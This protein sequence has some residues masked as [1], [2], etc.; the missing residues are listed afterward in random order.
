MKIKSNTLGKLQKI[1]NGNVFDSPYIFIR[2][3]LQNSQRSKASN[4]TF[5]LDNDAFVCKDDGCGCKNPENVFTLDL[6]EWESTTE[7][8]GIGFW[9]CLAIPDIKKIIV[10]SKDWKCTVDA[11]NLFETGDLTVKQEKAEMIKGFEVTIISPWFCNFGEYDNIENYL[12][13]VAKYLPMKVSINEFVVPQYDIFDNYKATNFCKVYD[14]RLFKAK[15]E[16]NSSYYSNITLYYEKRKV[17][18][19]CDCDYV[20]GIIEAKNGKITLKEPDRTSYTR[21]SKLQTFLDKL[22]DCIKDLYKSYVQEN[23]VENDDFVHGIETWLELKDYEK[24][25]D[26]DDEM[27]EE[28]QEII[29]IEPEVTVPITRLDEE[30]ASVETFHK[31]DQETKQTFRVAAKSNATYS[32][33]VVNKAENKKSSKLESFK[34][35]IKKMKKSVWVQKNEYSIYS[36]AIQEAKYKGLNVIVAKNNLYAQALRNYGIVHIDDLHNAFREVYMKKN[37]ELKNGKEEAFI[38]LLAPI[39]HKYNLPEDTFLIADLSIESQFVVDDKIVFKRN[40]KN[41]KNAIQ[42]YGV[43][44]RR[45]IYLDRNAIALQKFGLKQGNVHIGVSEI[46]ALLH[47]VNTIAHEL[48]HLIEGTT[49]NTPEHYQAEIRHQQE[50]ISLYV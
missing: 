20:C 6:S 11:V 18:D 21:D 49:D 50:I 9:S 1:K 34:D 2:E 31:Q 46:K 37:I 29:E 39:C 14:N 48:A 45:Y 12:F 25:L 3:L 17:R 35:K 13:D 44:D 30:Q 22:Q 19:F 32:E 42:I 23:G 36:D 24:M 38:A 28:A 26:F 16:I 15:L 40:I 43:T 41:K 47:N 5:E 10:H 27:L 8:Y 7:G 4:V 33:P